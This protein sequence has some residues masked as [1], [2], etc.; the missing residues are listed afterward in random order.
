MK[1][2]L[3]IDVVEQPWLSSQVVSPNHLETS[4]S[5]HL[6]F[7]EVAY[8]DSIS[9]TCV[10]SVSG[11]AGGVTKLGFPEPLSSLLYHLIEI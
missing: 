7:Q 1:Q 4:L 6:T 5:S 2:H 9:G 8:S 3:L 10:I 11:L